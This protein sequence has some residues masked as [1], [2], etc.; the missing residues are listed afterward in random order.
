MIQGE[1]WFALECQKPETFEMRYRLRIN[2]FLDLYVE[3]EDDLK[4]PFGLPASHVNRGIRRSRRRKCSPLNELLMALD[5]LVNYP[6][7]TMDKL[8]SEFGVG[9]TT[10]NNIVYHVI[11][12]IAELGEI[13]Y[14]TP[15]EREAFVILTQTRLDP[16]MRLI[17]GWRLPDA[18]M[19]W[20]VAA[21][22]STSMGT[23]VVL[24][25][26]QLPCVSTMEPLGL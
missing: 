10:A 3:I 14:P 24:F 4:K 9:R 15:E 26:I 11:P 12:L 7:R 19:H 20:C 25:R 13:R 2:E 5:F 21:S 1:G 8:G 22:S 18:L 23:G 17:T 16:L 6:N